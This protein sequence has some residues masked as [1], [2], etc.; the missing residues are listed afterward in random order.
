MQ[1]ALFWDLTQQLELQGFGKSSYHLHFQT[2]TDWYWLQDS[3]STVLRILC[4][5][6]HTPSKTVADIPVVDAEG[7]VKGDIIVWEDS[8]SLEAAEAPVEA[9]TTPSKAVIVDENSEPVV[10]DVVE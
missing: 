9:S 8:P 4:A 3:W 6:R 7:D 5:S 10:N 2:Y 1:Q